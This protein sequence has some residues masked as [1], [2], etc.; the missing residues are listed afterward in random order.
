MAIENRCSLSRE[1]LCSRAL[2]SIRQRIQAK[3]F[4]I[5]SIPLQTPERWQSQ[6]KTEDGS[7]MRVSASC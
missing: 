3:A 4:S 6:R 1:P 7:R 5:L 2:A